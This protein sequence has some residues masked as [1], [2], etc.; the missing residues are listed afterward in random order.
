MTLRL[1]VGR[2]ILALE[3]RVRV[4][5]GQPIQ[6]RSSIKVMRLIVSQENEGQYLDLVPANVRPYGGVRDF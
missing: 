6:A 5:Q 2:Q 4:Q 1:M 3:M